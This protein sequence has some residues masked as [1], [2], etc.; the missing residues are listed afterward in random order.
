MPKAESVSAR[1]RSHLDLPLIGLNASGEFC[2]V[3][4]LAER[5]KRLIFGTARSGWLTCMMRLRPS[6]RPS[7]AQT[8]PR[9]APRLSG[10]AAP[11]GYLR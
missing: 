1:C 11:D 4:S 9:S 5:A 6:L 3:L 10:M 8:P 2:V 7:L